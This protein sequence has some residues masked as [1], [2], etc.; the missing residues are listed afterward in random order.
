[1]VPS[2]LNATP[3]GP[4]P[5]A[6]AAP[7]TPVATVIGVTVPEAVLTTYAFVPSG[8]K[9]TLCGWVPTVIA[10]PGVFVATVMGVTVPEPLLVT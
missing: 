10:V 8:L 6:I 5:T 2:G 9:A 1:M 4:E 3:I 7:A